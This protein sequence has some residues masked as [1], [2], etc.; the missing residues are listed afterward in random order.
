MLWKYY[1]VLF[2][3]PILQEMGLTLNKSTAEASSISKQ[4]A[5]VCCGFQVEWQNSVH[6]LC[7]MFLSFGGCV[8]GVTASAATSGSKIDTWHQ[9]LP[10]SK[11]MSHQDWWDIILE[12]ELELTLCS[13]NEK[14]FC[15][16]KGMYADAWQWVYLNAF[17][18]D[19]SIYINI[20]MLNM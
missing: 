9:H 20:Q 12:F 10:I 13:N 14:L 16:A 7:S 6:L 2:C 5:Q 11:I 8:I 15:G 4:C 17:H 19:F 3:F 18:A 1:G